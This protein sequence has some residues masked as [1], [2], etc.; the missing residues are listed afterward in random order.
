MPNTPEPARTRSSEEDPSSRMS[1]LEHLVELRKRL[2][3]SL[4]YIGVGVIV[5]LTISDKAYTFLAEPMLKAL[6][7]AHVAD[8]LIYTS[9]IG[10]ITLYITVGLYLGLVLALPLVLYQVWLFIAPGLY[11]HERKAV[12]WFIG[13]AMVLFLSGTAFGYYIMLPASLKFLLSIQGPFTPMISINEYFDLNLVILVGLGLVF[14]LPIL[15]FFLTLFGVVTPRFLW[16]NVRFAILIIAVVAAIVTPTTDALT[17]L[18]F[19]A[20][21]IVLYFVGIG[22]SALVVRN[23][24]RAKEELA[25]ADASQSSDP[26]IL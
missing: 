11:R 17:M 22:V 4:A 24:R 15:I 14:Q 25:R 16:Q 10:P 9:P 7:D 18:I 6:R 23:K 1:F 3:Y 8:R 20:P 19:M 2:L 12:A 26:L 13:S 21:M 5:G